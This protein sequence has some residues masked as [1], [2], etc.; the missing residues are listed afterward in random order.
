[1]KLL[2]L[3]TYSWPA[4]LS[5]GLISLVKG[6]V[7]SAWE[8]AGHPQPGPSV[9]G[10]SLLRGDTHSTSFRMW[11]RGPSQPPQGWVPG[12]S[13]ETSPSLF[14]SL[15]NEA[16]PSCFRGWHSGEVTE[17]WERQLFLAIQLSPLPARNPRNEGFPFQGWLQLNRLPA[18]PGLGWDDSCD[19]TSHHRPW[20][21]SEAVQ[22]HTLLGDWPPRRGRAPEERGRLPRLSPFGLPHRQHWQYNLLK[23]DSRPFTISSDVTAFK[24]VL[25]LSL[26]YREGNWGLGRCSHLSKVLVELGLKQE[27]DCQASKLY[28]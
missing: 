5:L 23:R 20:T 9:L 11:Q 10:Y 15:C 22:R 2:V 18:T 6:K 17:T 26:F 25:L 16:F 24:Q 21:A 14:P 8:V 4:K 27:S 1:M 28:S 3:A 19:G 7:A 12:A 13:H